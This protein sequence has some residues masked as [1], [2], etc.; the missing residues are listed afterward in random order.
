[1]RAGGVRAPRAGSAPAP[2]RYGWPG[3]GSRRCFLLLSARVGSRSVLDVACGRRADCRP[4]LALLVRTVDP[5]RSSRSAPE[6]YPR[7][8]CIGDCGSKTAQCAAVDPRSRQPPNPAGVSYPIGGNVRR[9]CCPDRRLNAFDPQSLTR[10]PLQFNPGATVVAGRRP[11]AP[12]AL[13]RRRA[14]P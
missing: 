12:W 13:R 3:Y 5:V 2:D 10:D 8:V 9:D 11:A 1:M 4:D 7:R 6:L 14:A